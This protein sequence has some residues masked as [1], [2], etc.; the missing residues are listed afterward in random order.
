L[1]AHAPYEVHNE[2]RDA[3]FVVSG[4]DLKG[5]DN[6]AQPG[7]FSFHSK[8]NI[9]I[10]TLQEDAEYKKAYE[11]DRHPGE[12]FDEF[13]VRY[14]QAKAAKENEERAA[15]E[16]NK[17]Q[18]RLEAVGQVEEKLKAW[19]FKSGVQRNLRNLLSSLNTILWPDCGWK[20][21]SMADLMDSAGVEKWFKKARFF[22]HPD[23]QHDLTPE[24]EV[25]VQKVYEAL[26][27]AHQ[28]YL[29]EG[30]K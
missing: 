10:T 6:N 18:A 9:R 19:Q 14:R 27:S 29:D 23:R 4:D 26:Q 22:V 21:P 30:S 15:A 13:V 3:T 24:Q 17:Q 7:E 8:P 5:G 1:G 25:I 12:S 16:A 28:K 20:G 2:A 11:E